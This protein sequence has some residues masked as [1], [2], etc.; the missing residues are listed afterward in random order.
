MSPSGKGGGFNP[1]PQPKSS[2]IRVDEV[3]RLTKLYKSVFEDQPLIKWSII[4]AGFG[5]LLDGLH[6]LWLV[7]K[8]ALEK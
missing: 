2:S 1:A 4:A 6:V 7:L 8:H 3:E 5:G